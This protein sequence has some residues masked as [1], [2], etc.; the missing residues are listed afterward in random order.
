MT[1]CWSLVVGIVSGSN[2]FGAA[3]ISQFDVKL[4]WVSITPF[5]S[6]VVPEENGTMHT[7]RCEC[8]RDS[9]DSK[10]LKTSKIKIIYSYIVI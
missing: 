1:S 4:L 2:G 7:S 3:N 9:C 5:G 6:P 10:D 8:D